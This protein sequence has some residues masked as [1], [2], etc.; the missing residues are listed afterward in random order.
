MS[1][2]FKS[3]NFLNF[4]SQNNTL[5]LIINK[6]LLRIT[7]GIH[8]FKNKANSGNTLDLRKAKELGRFKDTSKADVQVAEKVED[9]Q[10]R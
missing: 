7:K 3:D 8:T 1:P 6:T 9:V 5:E 2:K 4:H 10:V